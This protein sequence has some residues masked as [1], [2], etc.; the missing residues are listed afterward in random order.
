[1]G[2]HRKRVD[3][4]PMKYYGGLFYNMVDGGSGNYWYPACPTDGNGW[5]DD[6]DRFRNNP[7]RRWLKIEDLG[8]G[9]R[10]WFE[11][12]CNRSEC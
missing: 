10:N 3:V 11:T 12:V 4:G 5:S 6:S 8:W 2:E 7:S 1:M 9:S